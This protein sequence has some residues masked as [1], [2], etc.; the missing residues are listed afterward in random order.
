MKN[1]ADDERRNL[2]TINA[3]SGLYEAS[4]IGSGE[5][6]HETG[7]STDTGGHF[8]YLEDNHTSVV[9]MRESVK[10]R[11]AR[12]VCVYLSEAFDILQVGSNTWTQTTN[13]LTFDRTASSSS[14]KQRAHGSF[15]EIFSSN[16]SQE[17][18]DRCLFAF[19]AQSNFSGKRY[20]LPWIGR[21]QEQ[22]HYSGSKEE[23]EVT[24]NF[25][26]WY[27]LLDAAS[28]V[29][30]ADLDLTRYPADFI[31]LSFY[32]MF[33]FPT[34][35]G[36]LLV[37]NSSSHTLEKYYFGGGTVKVAITTEDYHVTKD[38]LS[39]R[40]EDGTPPFLEILAL[41]YGFDTLERITASVV[42]KYHR[43]YPVY[44]RLPGEMTRG[45]V[46][47]EEDNS[48]SVDD[49]QATCCHG[50]GQPV[51][52]IYCDTEFESP[53]LQG[54]I[55]NFNLLKASGE[56]YGYAEV[57]KLALVYNIQLRTS[58]FCNLGACQHHLGIDAQK[59]K[60]NYNAG[61]VCG[62]NMDLIDGKPTGSVRISFGYM[63]TLHDVRA[64][65]KF[66]HECFVDNPTMRDADPDVFYDAV[67]EPVTDV[68]ANAVEAYAE[69]GHGLFAEKCTSTDRIEN[70]ASL[71]GE[72]ALTHQITAQYTE[73]VSI[74]SDDMTLNQIFLYPI[75]SC[76]AFHVTEWPIGKRG[77]LYDREW[78]IVTETGICLTQKREPLMCL[79]RPFINL[80]KDSLLL[81]YPGAHDLCLNLKADPDLSTEG[82]NLCRSK[83][84][85]DSVTGV[86]CGDEVSLWLEDVLCR[87][88][89]RLVRQRDSRVT[90]SGK[91]HR[92]DV[93]DNLS[94]ANEAQFLLI[95]RSSV[96]AVC[97]RINESEQNYN[98]IIDVQ[99]AVRRFR[100]NLV[101]STMKPFAEE[102]WTSV[103]IGTHLF[104]CIR[105]CSRC[106]MICINQ[107][108]G[109]RTK[110]PLKSLM[111]IRQKPHFGILMQHV[112]DGGSRMLK[113]GEK[114]V[115]VTR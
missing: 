20:P 27:V 111:R 71:I 33:G 107:E 101:V 99:S 74:P 26:R 82:A 51:A 95:N 14:S 13:G 16:S 12:G 19:P 36:A 86:D 23:S 46:H 42:T 104:Q 69:C 1:S 28:Y 29:T 102:E 60:D 112:S 47:L 89:L 18:R 6:F 85:T 10:R 9:G 87:T 113:T 70:R 106:Q 5:D 52:K 24:E 64:F 66:V 77:L 83:V 38:S 7:R 114:L 92:S 11:G 79:I 75:K 43:R 53:Q 22:R 39:E 57:E 91:G 68:D 65:L 88:G 93:R 108:T 73:D 110:E 37:R 45:L 67:E 81:T 72:E 49:S 32:K 15:G 25:R 59:I 17:R 35:L 2:A 80:E 30:T 3:A 78:M 31:A 90:K 105:T 115:T 76:G 96:A 54:P 40:F 8:C 56:Y 97:D 21:I 41:R 94:L 63:S 4:K 34:G 103:N 48:H 50:N 44:K 100:A 98:Q 61:H 84:C 109:V 62:D 58:C 55:L